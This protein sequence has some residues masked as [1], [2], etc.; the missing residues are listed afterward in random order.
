MLAS[1]LAAVAVVYVLGGVI[2]RLYF[3]PIAGF[4]GPKLAAVTY[5]YEFYYDVVKDGQYIFQIAKLHKR[6]GR[7]S[8]QFL[9]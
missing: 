3:S 1:I 5:W 8:A 6:Y 9:G 4:P 2:Y 7:W